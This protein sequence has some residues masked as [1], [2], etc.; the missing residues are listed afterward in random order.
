MAPDETTPASREDA[1]QTV[2]AS[3]APTPEPTAFR[4]VGPLA[5]IKLGGGDV[6]A[7][8]SAMGTVSA[9]SLSATGSAIGAASVDGDATITAS[10]VPALIARGDTTFQQSYASAVIVGGGAETKLHQAFAPLIVGKTMDLTQSGACALVTGEADVKSSWIGLVLSPKTNVSEDSH[11]IISTRAA[12]IIALALFGG[13]GLVAL[14]ITLGVRRVVRWR[15]TIGL[16]S[17]PA[18]PSLPSSI[19]LPNLAELQERWTHRSA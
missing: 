3:D 6:Q 12:L 14:A 9:G 17:L 15:P 19:N 2:P 8:L 11:V 4:K 16:P 10:M 1:V 7:N 18:L 5:A 13:F